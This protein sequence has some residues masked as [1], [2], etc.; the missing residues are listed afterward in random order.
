[1]CQEAHG[2]C[3]WCYTCHSAGRQKGVLQHKTNDTVSNNQ[4]PDLNFEF[5]MSQKIP[6]TE[7]VSLVSLQEKNH[8]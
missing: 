8:A 5:E 7:A 4:R 1:M 6:K 3:H 2:G